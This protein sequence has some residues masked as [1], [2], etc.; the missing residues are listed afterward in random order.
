MFSRF[1][2]NPITTHWWL[3]SKMHC[4]PSLVRWVIRDWAAV[5]NCIICDLSVVLFKRSV[6]VFFRT[7]RQWKHTKNPQ[8]ARK[9][10]HSREWKGRQGNKKRMWNRQRSGDWP[11][12]GQWPWRLMNDVLVDWHY[13]G[14]EGT[15][16]TSN[17]QCCLQMTNASTR[18]VHL[19]DLSCCPSF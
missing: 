11:F 16:S 14:C 2:L 8:A 7:I 17:D 1:G 18:R 3:E 13:L 6:R 4:S 9:T 5:L 10:L 12:G 15:T 19:N